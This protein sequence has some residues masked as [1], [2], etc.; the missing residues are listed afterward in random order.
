MDPT[1]QSKQAVLE[2]MG[3]VSALRIGRKSHFYMISKR[4]GALIC[5]VEKRKVKGSQR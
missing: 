2:E 1:F 4:Y 3:F 5:T